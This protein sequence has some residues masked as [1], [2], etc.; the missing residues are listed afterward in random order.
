MMC[1][2]VRNSQLILLRRR[3]RYRMSLLFTSSTDSCSRARPMR[4][5]FPRAARLMGAGR[6][7][8]RELPRLPSKPLAGR[9]AFGGERHRHRDPRLRDIVGYCGVARF[10]FS[11][12]PL[13]NA[14]GR[15]H[16]LASQKQTLLLALV[17][18][19]KCEHAAHD[20]AIAACLAR[21]ARLEKG[22]CQ[23]GPPCAGGVGAASRRSGKSAAHGERHSSQHLE[24]LFSHRA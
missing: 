9:A 10:L 2:F 1:P 23:C 8:R 12:F 21:R 22:L 14:A 3:C 17:L 15:P 5:S 6:P 11:D 18:L 19:Q 24:P 7:S 4:R 16:D 20:L 13:G